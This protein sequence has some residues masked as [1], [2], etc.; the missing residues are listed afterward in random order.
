MR[1]IRLVNR[2]IE[3]TGMASRFYR[4]AQRTGKEQLELVELEPAIMPAMLTEEEEIELEA[5]AAADR[6]EI[7]E[8]RGTKE[9]L[10]RIAKWQLE[11]RVRQAE[12]EAARAREEAEK[13]RQE[14]E[15]ALRI[16]AETQRELAA[17]EEE[18]ERGR[19][20][21]REREAFGAGLPT[22]PKGPSEGLDAREAAGDLRS[23]DERGQETRSQQ[24]VELRL[25]NLH[26]ADAAK[27]GA[28][29]NDECLC[30]AEGPENKNRAKLH[31]GR[32]SPEDDKPPPRLPR[33]WMT[34][35]PA[36]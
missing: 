17:A 34:F 2:M 12:E 23:A 8:S 7:R 19:G 13:A 6:A 16:L 14:L 31:D 21:E 1:E 15:G 18:R 29:A 22:S 9:E 32:A 28:S 5:Q 3:R 35:T 26:N 10:E 20:G 25:H 27:N 30:D 33:Q 24:V 4:L 11:E 36:K